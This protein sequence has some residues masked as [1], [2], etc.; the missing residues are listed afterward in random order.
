M[1]RGNSFRGPASVISYFYLMIGPPERAYSRLIGLVDH[2]LNENSLPGKVPFVR[3]R[4][5]PRARVENSFT[6]GNATIKY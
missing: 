3:I 4:N 5:I 6:K 2:A 1:E